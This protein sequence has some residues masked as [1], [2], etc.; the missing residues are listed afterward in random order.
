MT[1]RIGITG[2]AKQYIP[3]TLYA[4]ASYQTTSNLRSVGGTILTMGCGPIYHRSKIIK[5][6]CDS[7]TEAEIY[8]LQDAAKILMWTQRVLEDMGF[9]VKSKIFE[10]NEAAITLVTSHGQSHANK[11]K[12]MAAKIYWMDYYIEKNMFEIEHISTHRMLADAYTKVMETNKKYKHLQK[13]ISGHSN[14]GISHIDN[15]E[16][17]EQIR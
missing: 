13:C 16:H 8:V 6:P 10:D 5:I 9:Q 4:D 11:T 3:L 15:L 17:I 7:T 12:H 14:H 2:E 1:I